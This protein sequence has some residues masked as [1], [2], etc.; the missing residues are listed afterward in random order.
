M[1]F[2]G[3][4]QCYCLSALL[5]ELTL[6]LGNPL[7]AGSRVIP[8]AIDPVDVVGGN[9]SEPGLYAQNPSFSRCL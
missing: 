1:C 8:S 9:I 4:R 7:E 6:L 5:R 3:L 2:Y